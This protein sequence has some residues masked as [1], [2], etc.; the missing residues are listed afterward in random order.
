MIR[1]EIY[2]RSKFAQRMGVIYFHKIR[3]V[4]KTGGN[5][6]CCIHTTKFL[7][8]KRIFEHYRKEFGLIMFPELYKKKRNLL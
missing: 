2:T 8:A 1:P 5:V 6:M 3:N 7:Q 4:E